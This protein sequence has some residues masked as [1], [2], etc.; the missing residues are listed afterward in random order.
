MTV[1]RVPGDGP[2]NFLIFILYLWDSDIATD[3]A[4]QA[5]P[6]DI[7]HAVEAAQGYS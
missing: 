6:L 3:C 5:A 4:E 7:M 2:G 1:R